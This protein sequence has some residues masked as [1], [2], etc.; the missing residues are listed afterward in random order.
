MA[1]CAYRSAAYDFRGHRVGVILAARLRD[2]QR[3]R[4]YGADLIQVRGG[5]DYPVR[6][7]LQRPSAGSPRHRQKR[8]C[9]PPLLPSPRNKVDTSA[10]FAFGRDFSLT[11]CPGSTERN[12]SGTR[13]CKGFW[14]PLVLT[15]CLRVALGFGAGTRNTDRTRTVFLKTGFCS[16]LYRTKQVL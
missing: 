16:R 13:A 2:P 10:S 6:P 8:S 7:G 4:P 3:V 11:L 5:P 14:G 9:A 12:Q 15:A 1:G